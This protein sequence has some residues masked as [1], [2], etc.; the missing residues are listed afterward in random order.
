MGDQAVKM[1]EEVV[2]NK[3]CNSAHNKSSSLEI[4]TCSLKGKP[5]EIGNGKEDCVGQSKVPFSDSKGKE[6]DLESHIQ[7][8]LALVANM[9]RY[10]G[11]FNQLGIGGPLPFL[12]DSFTLKRASSLE[13]LG[14]GFSVH[15]DVVEEHGR[16][17]RAIS[18]VNEQVIEKVRELDCNIDSLMSYGR[19]CIE[20]WRTEISGLAHS[21]YEEVRNLNQRTEL[22]VN[23]CSNLE[24]KIDQLCDEV[25]LLRNENKLLKEKYESLVIERGKEGIRPPVECKCNAGRSDD[26]SVKEAGIEI[27]RLQ[28]EIENIKRVCCDEFGRLENLICQGLKTHFTSEDEMEFQLRMEEEDEEEKVELK[29]MRATTRKEYQ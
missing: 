9:N 23:G 4:E 14:K 16:K 12:K 15:S 28:T 24:A 3:K 11:P 10:Q 22:I 26:D 21:T 5:L 20:P 7:M 19:E 13:D 1:V 18:N 2:N 25:E 27:N 17:L 8:L 29:V 6:C